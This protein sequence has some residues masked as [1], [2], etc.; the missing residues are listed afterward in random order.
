M[1]YRILLYLRKLKVLNILLVLFVAVS[2]VGVALSLAQLKQN[3]DAN[4]KY[5][6]IDSF[7]TISPYDVYDMTG[8]DSENVVEVEKEI[9]DLIIKYKSDERVDSMKY[10]FSTNLTTEEFAEAMSA[11]NSFS[12]FDFTSS[13]DDLRFDY[14]IPDDFDST[15]FYI[16]EEMQTEFGWQV[17]DQV[18][19]SARVSE[20]FSSTGV[21]TSEREQVGTAVVH[22]IL[23]KNTNELGSTSVGGPD[24]VEYLYAVAYL[25]IEV[26]ETITSDKMK[27]S[28][29]TISMG[30]DEKYATDI[31]DELSSSN[32]IIY[33]SKDVLEKDL[34]FF[35]DISKFFIYL[36]V[37]SIVMLIS[38][39]VALNN[40]VLDR[41]RQELQLY[42]IF[43]QSFNSVKIQF[44]IEKVILVAIALIF[45]VPGALWAF[46]KTTNIINTIIEYSFNTELKITRL[47]F[48]SPYL[49]FQSE[50]GFFSLYTEY[51][52][53]QVNKPL[54]I[55]TTLLIVLIIILLISFL[56]IS[57][58]KLR[59]VEQRRDV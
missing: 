10:R 9:Y 4:K 16:T 11:E 28:N 49:D 34:E 5:D 26:V 30:V 22:G 19:L 47:I 33:Y 1:L 41:R 7:F 3:Y 42:N 29:T 38:T 52:S 24:G 45:A 36:L 25:P 59:I 14:E 58:Q 8:G 44:L 46:R 18:N 15:K 40:N 23:K 32:A 57:V 48:E 55:I 54:I 27:V 51:V 53:I 35:R 6:E 2:F 21:F 12:Y 17:G 50:K 37:I 20:S 56:Q 31:K 43:G 13:I 39:F